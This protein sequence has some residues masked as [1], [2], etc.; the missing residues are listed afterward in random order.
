MDSRRARLLSATSSKI[1]QSSA[2][3]IVLM[4]I[5]DQIAHADAQAVM[6]L[7]EVLLRQEY[8]ES[9]SLRLEGL[10]EGKEGPRALIEKARKALAH[11][12]TPHMG[13]AIHHGTQVD[14]PCASCPH[15]GEYMTSRP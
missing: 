15:E 14:A 6:W 4:E 10:V 2:P 7:E 9:L 13:L 5:E 11:Q 1:V 12:A 8:L 3:G